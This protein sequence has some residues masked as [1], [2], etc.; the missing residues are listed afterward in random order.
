MRSTTLSFEERGD[1]IGIIWMNDEQEPVNTLKRELITEFESLFSDIERRNDINVLVFASAKPDS[2]I[3]GA[4]LG[5][6]QDIKSAEEAR[7]LAQSAQSIQ[8]RIETLSAASVAAIH[9]P[10]LGGGLEFT[11]AFDSRIASGDKQTRLGL[12]E[13]QLGLLPGGGGTQ[14]L[15]RLIGVE[16]ALDMLLTGRQ[17]SAAK[18]RRIGLI[19]EVVARHILIDAAV[20]RGKRLRLR[21]SQQT[22]GKL[23]LKYWRNW[24]LSGNPLGR[25]FL[26]DQA[27]RRTRHKTRG[28]YPAP[29][30][31]LEVVRI[32][33]EQG[34]RQGLAAEAEAFGRMVMSPQSTQLINLFHTATALKKETGVQDKSV[35]PREI[36]KIG[37]LG[38]GLMGAGIA[39]ASISKAE[40]PVRLKDKDDPGVRQ[41]LVYVEKLLTERLEKKSLTTL[42]RAQILAR[43]T[44]STNYNGIRNCDLVIEA[45]FEELALKQQM[46]RD[47]ESLEPA[48]PI[49]FAT[50]TSAIPIKSIAA[51]ARSARTVIGMHY[52]SP[53]E[54]MPLLEIVVTEE[55]A[56]WVIATCVELG[57]RQGKTVIV[58]NDGPGFYTTRILAP[59]LAE[60]GH[61]LQQGVAIERI[62]ESLKNFGFPIGPLAL[63]D[64]VGIDVGQKVGQNLHQAFGDR[65]QPVAAMARL[66]ADN[67]MGRK[68]KR[69]L[70][71]YADNRTADAREVDTSVY[72]LLNVEPNNAPSS[73]SIAERC[74][75]QMINEAA[76][77]LNE[78]ILRTARDG[79][80]GAVFGL[81]FPPF[82][83]GP[84][85]YL[86]TNGADILSKLQRLSDQHGARFQPAPP[87]QEGQRFY[88]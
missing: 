61:L 12:P 45:V 2:F 88:P 56:P 65:M 13:V 78:G 26:F 29:E 43:L 57:K 32:G 52:F 49:I 82:L 39:Y 3:A 6:L 73:Q 30:N 51:A 21:R 54:K 24:A 67:R 16:K 35:K 20:E 18:A 76:H 34:L 79:D 48:T 36:K 66:V 72:E 71:R 69:G 64:E 84:F 53:V 25:H 83:G 74:A 19:D 86:D 17:L 22:P 85:R 33:L 62:D 60:A 38:A 8:D 42:E 1:G 77:C 40:T 55:T 37:V 31:I 9:G 46:L 11:L 10:C 87:I 68:N 58:V 4:N 63:L 59:Y 23:N 27:R 50:N 44:G 41:G 7:A 81:G 47:I 5:M 70:Y 80:I 14:R 15:P 75:L 28:N